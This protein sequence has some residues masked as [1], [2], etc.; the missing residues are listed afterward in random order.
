MAIGWMSDWSIATFSGGLVFKIVNDS[1]F[2]TGQI[3][4][5]WCI[6]IKVKASS[7]MQKFQEIS[8]LQKVK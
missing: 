6:N 3:C 2:T 4:D 8:F 7:L 5:L 1:S